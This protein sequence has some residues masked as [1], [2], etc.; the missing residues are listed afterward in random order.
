MEEAGGRAGMTT[1]TAGRV[2]RLERPAASGVV[3][4]S[5]AKD[6]TPE[7]HWCTVMP[8]LVSVDGAGRE[9]KVGFGSVS[10]VDTNLF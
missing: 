5:S 3:N 1:P 7:Q 10:V 2:A 8:P 6:L 9:H 4:K